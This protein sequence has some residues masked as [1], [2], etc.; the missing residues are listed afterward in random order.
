[1]SNINPWK[2]DVSVLCIFFAREDI[3][4][5]T[6]EAIRKA[7]PRRLLLWQDGARENHPEDMKHILKCRE[8]AENI[9]WDC[10]VHRLYNEKNYGCD[11]STFYSHKWAF[12]IVDKCIVIEDDVVASEDFFLFCKEMLD[13]YENDTRICRICGMNQVKDFE[14]DD[15]YF[16]S[17]IGAVW[18][19][20]T[21]KRVADSWDEN[22]TFLND[23]YAM[24]LV[25]NAHNEKSFENYEKV[26]R[27]HNADGKPHWETIQTYSR[28]LNSQLSIIPKVN[29]IKNIGLGEYS[30][31]SNVEI[32]CI[33]KA[34]REAYYC[35][36]QKL[37][38]PLKH[39]KYVI[40]NVEYK[41]RLFK[42]IGKNHPLTAKYRKL[43]GL[44]LKVR[45]YGVG[46]IFKRI[47]K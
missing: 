23:E 36:A 17:S 1:M 6:F 14:C 46:Y 45:H 43:Q 19:W 12:S 41:E 3:F 35:D 40:D 33:P 15:S 8:I 27:S 44:F 39:P 32:E 26:C 2:I 7:R 28:Y 18:G 24:K 31:H 11:P 47:F 38:F 30:T 29:L 16:F 10:E 5:K 42:I 34:L 9:D 4:E 21:W 13:R 37:E 22:Y 25:R 20:A